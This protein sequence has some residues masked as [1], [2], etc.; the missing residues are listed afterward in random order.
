LFNYI[1]KL[2]HSPANA[3]YQKSEVKTI[4]NNDLR[5]QYYF[6]RIKRL[7]HVSYDTRCNNP[8]M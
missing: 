7:S 1:N 8:P 6:L 4:F 5:H 2:L 3:K